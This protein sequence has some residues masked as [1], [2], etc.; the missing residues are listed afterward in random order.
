[1][2]KNREIKIILHNFLQNCHNKFIKVEKRKKI[3][4]DLIK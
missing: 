3:N 1:M 2:G 4:N